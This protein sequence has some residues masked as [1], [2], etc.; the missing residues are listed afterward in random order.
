MSEYPKILYVKEVEE[1]EPADNFLLCAADPTDLSEPDITIEIAE[2]QFVKVR[3]LINRTKF[4][5]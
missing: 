2:Y 3:K 1:R 4:T 5:D